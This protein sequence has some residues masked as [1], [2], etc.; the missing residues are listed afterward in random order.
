MAAALSALQ[1]SH[2]EKGRQGLNA[3]F[4]ELFALL[5]VYIQFAQKSTN[6]SSR[7][8]KLNEN[9]ARKWSADGF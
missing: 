5:R 1:P 4:F 9:A 6:Y 3:R 8:N 2:S 7:H